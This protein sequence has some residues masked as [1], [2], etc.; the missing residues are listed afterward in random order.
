MVTVP[1]IATTNAI[2]RALEPI[3]KRF[4]LVRAFWA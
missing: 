1:I 4:A 3:V 2:A